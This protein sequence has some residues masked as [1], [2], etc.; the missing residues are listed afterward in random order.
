MINYRTYTKLLGQPLVEA[1]L[2]LNLK[3]GG[4]KTIKKGKDDLRPNIS[5]GMC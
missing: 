1:K 5:L 2:A 4:E 3:E